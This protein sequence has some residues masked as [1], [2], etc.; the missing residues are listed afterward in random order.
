MGSPAQVADALVE[1]HRLGVRHLTMRVSWPGMS[2]D[3][4]LESIELLGRDVLPD[5]RNR[6]AAGA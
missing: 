4:I 1:Q 5:V 2:Q 3:H 6:I